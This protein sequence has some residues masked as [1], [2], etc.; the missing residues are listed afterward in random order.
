M[1]NYWDQRR[2]INLGFYLCCVR[3]LDL[4]HCR[5]SSIN[6][7]IPSAFTGKYVY[8]PFAK[9]SLKVRLEAYWVMMQIR[10]S[11]LL[12]LK[13]MLRLSKKV[14]TPPL[15]DRWNLHNYCTSKKLE[16]LSQTNLY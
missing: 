11:S 8:K 1:K 6:L 4:L 16:W 15:K 2:M 12:Y 14:I 7:I 5:Q 13:N 10:G 3:G 9:T